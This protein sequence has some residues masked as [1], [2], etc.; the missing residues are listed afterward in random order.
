MKEKAI[1]FSG[2]VYNKINPKFYLK[3]INKEDFIICA[4]AGTDFALKLSITPHLILGDFDSIKPN[5]LKNYKNIKTIKYEKEKDYTDTE[6]ALEK[7]VEIKPSEI[8]IFGALGGRIDHTLA[9]IFLLKKYAN[10]NTNIRIIDSES[11]MMFV[12]NDTVIYGDKGDT[13]SLIPVSDIVKGVSTSNLYYALHR[14]NLSMG[15]TRGVSNV[16]LSDSAE[17][18][19]ESG[20]LLMIRTFKDHPE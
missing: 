3:Y 7:A 11:E 8:I 5:T 15:S 9:N 19:I 2:G 4:D 10:Y 17:V 16:M 12:K 13:V 14:E 20:E 6:I 1:I 18:S